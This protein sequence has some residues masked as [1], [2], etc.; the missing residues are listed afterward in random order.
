MPKA[1]YTK[2]AQTPVQI[3]D[4]LI[5]QGLLVQTQAERDTAMCYLGFVGGYRLKGYWFHL[6]NHQ[7]KQ[8]PTGTTFQNIVDRFEF[9]RDLRGLTTAVIDRVEVAVRCAMS[10]YMSIKHSP[11]WFLNTSLFRP[12]RDWKCGQ[13]LSKIETEVGRATAKKFIAHYFDKYEEPYLPPSWAVSECVSFGLWSQTYRI[14]REPADK[15]AISMKFGVDQ[16]DV[17]QSW[18]HAVSVTRNIAAHQGQLLRIKL[19]ITPSNY[20]SK[21]IK[22]S[23]DKSFYSVV[24]VINYLLKSSGL[25]NNWRQDLQNLFARYP[26]IDPVELGFSLKWFNNPGWQ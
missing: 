11:H 26:N 9:D 3:L 22:F 10:N 19:P 6:I 5:N 16:T 4:K 14:F 23:D 12:T 2:A 21:N 20:K 18:L 8:F 24:T 25:P 1:T 17:F 13:L 7:T 15:K